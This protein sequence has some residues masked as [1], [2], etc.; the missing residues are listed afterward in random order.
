[1][2]K[3]ITRHRFA[4][5]K[6][7]QDFYGFRVL[8]ALGNH[9][10]KLLLVNIVIAKVK[11]SFFPVVSSKRLGTIYPSD[12]GRILQTKPTNFIPFL[13][14]NPVRNGLPKHLL[15]PFELLALHSL[16]SEF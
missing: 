2:T 6:T 15:S 1:M 8:I 16:V 14:L 5:F 9:I 11:N 10:V 4:F 13:S 3:L 12:D 7:F